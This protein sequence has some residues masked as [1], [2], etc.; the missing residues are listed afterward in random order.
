MKEILALLAMCVDKLSDRSTEL[1]PLLQT[2]AV[3]IGLCVIA[4]MVW[5][6]KP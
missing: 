5:K 1:T 2:V 4:L 3:I 6:G